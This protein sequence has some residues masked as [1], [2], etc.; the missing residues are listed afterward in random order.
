MLHNS[1]AWLAAR[2]R[3]QLALAENHAKK[4][5]ELAPDTPGYLDTLAEVQFQS[6]RKEAAIATMK[7]C[8][9]LDPDRPYY[10]KQLKR[11]EAGDPLADVPQS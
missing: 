1:L 2:C 3:R 8:I 7:R 9:E 5:V 11:F 6:G 4:A 10:R